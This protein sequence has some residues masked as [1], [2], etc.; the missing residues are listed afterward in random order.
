MSKLIITCEI[1]LD[2][3][4]EHWQGFYNRHVSPLLKHL[5][6]TIHWVITQ[7]NQ[8]TK[9][10]VYTAENTDFS[11]SESEESPTI[12][13][14]GEELIKCANPYCDEYFPYK[15]M[16]NQVKKYCSTKCKDDVNNQKKKAAAKLEN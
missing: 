16:G 6:I 14:I 11:L 1:D 15:K 2:K 12:E 3:I 5:N 9:N 13:K 7:C 10:A 8:N 4:K